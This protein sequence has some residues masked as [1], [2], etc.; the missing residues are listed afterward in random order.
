MIKLQH[1]LFLL[2][3]PSSAFLSDTCQS[4]HFPETL[5]SVNGVPSQWNVG[6]VDPVDTDSLYL[7][8]YLGNQPFFAKFE[9]NL[10]RYAWLHGMQTSEDTAKQ[11]WNL[12]ATEENSLLAALVESEPS[13]SLLLI[14]EKS[15]GA[16]LF[17]AYKM[18]HDA[19]SQITN[20]KPLR[21]ENMHW[22]DFESLWILFT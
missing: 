7:G 2:L 12:A 8:G 5:D 20:M 13:E 18:W 9:T 4:E 17:P 6:L 3:Q 10:M 15:S 11:V 1:Y 14:L 16:P 19:S 21:H 22:T